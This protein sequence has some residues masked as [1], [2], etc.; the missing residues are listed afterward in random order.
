MNRPERLTDLSPTRRALLGAGV[1]TLALS[2][3]L[4]IAPAWANNS[5]P[6]TVKI[7]DVSTGIDYGDSANNPTVC[8]FTI[9]FVF[10]E[11]VQSGTWEI[12]QQASGPWT[13][14]G[15][16]GAYDASGD[17]SDETD[18]IA[19]DAG[20]YKLEYQ[21]DGAHGSKSKAFTVGDGCG[22]ADATASPADD[23]SSDPTATPTATPTAVPTA[24]PTDESTPTA[25]PTDEST[26]TAT[27]TDES[28][29]TSDPTATPTA[30]PTATPT[31]A[32]TDEPASSPADHE[33]AVAGITSS[34]EPSAT[35]AVGAPAADATT[36]QLPD[37]SMGDTIP[38]TSLLTALGLLMIVGAH[39]F[40]RRSAHAD[41]A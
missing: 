37:T 36:D 10:P 19:L 4:S 27:P 15:V 20:H 23:P 40:I 13:A 6:G 17:G 7:H 1:A 35:P 18:K 24:T 41:R 33:G 16:S 5:N 11:G 32:P 34:S 26:P 14:T 8:T 12:L 28:T 22:A 9:V 2:L 25:T 30:V 31:A 29:V 21:A 38:L 3:V 39:P